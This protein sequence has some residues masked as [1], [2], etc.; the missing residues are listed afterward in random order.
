MDL[1]PYSFNERSSVPF[2]SYG[3]TNSIT[4]ITLYPHFDIQ[5]LESTV[6]AV[7]TAKY[8]GSLLYKISFD[9]SKPPNIT[10]DLPATSTNTAFFF[11]CSVRN[12][13]VNNITGYALYSYSSHGSKEEIPSTLYMQPSL[14]AFSVPNLGWSYPLHNV[15]N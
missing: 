15:Q 12:N 1:Y 9:I 5:H 7:F 10:V 11:D 2:Y 8:N 4:T 3:P 13:L 6:T 14:S